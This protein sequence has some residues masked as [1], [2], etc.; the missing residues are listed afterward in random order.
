MKGNSMVEVS[1]NIKNE[2]K[3]SDVVLFM[4]GS[5]D[6]PQCG[7]SAQVVE[8][9]NYFGIKFSSSFLFFFVLLK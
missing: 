9:L 8:I 1:E 7:F 2:I 6:F 5:P 4:K 3:S